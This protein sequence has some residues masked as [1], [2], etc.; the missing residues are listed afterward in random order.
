[1]AAWH[2]FISHPL[3]LA[4]AAPGMP[5]VEKGTH[6]GAVAGQRDTLIYRFDHDNIEYKAVVIDMFSQRVQRTRRALHR[7]VEAVNGTRQS[8][9]ICSTEIKITLPDVVPFPPTRRALPMSA[10]TVNGGC[11]RSFSRVA[12]A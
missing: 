2:G 8:R 4:F 6:S 7:S 12:F 5:K 3:G 10:Y 11:G 1:M 9:S